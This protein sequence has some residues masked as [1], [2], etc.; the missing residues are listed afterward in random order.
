M[1]ALT[2][3]ICNLH[4]ISSVKLKRF[5]KTWK[6][7]LTNLILNRLETFRDPSKSVYILT[8]RRGYE[9]YYTLVVL[10]SAPMS[11]SSGSSTVRES[12]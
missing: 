1:L 7:I 4:F 12:D 10:F 2:V 3:T 9:Y 6:L 11:K 5:C 8:R